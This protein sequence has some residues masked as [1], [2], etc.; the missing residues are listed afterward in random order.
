MTQPSGLQRFAPLSTPPLYSWLVQQERKQELPAGPQ[1]F[2]ADISLLFHQDPDV[3]LP[4]I[5][6][7]KC[8]L[9]RRVGRLAGDLPIKASYI[10]FGRESAEEGYEIFQEAMA[11]IGVLLCRHIHHPTNRFELAHLEQSDLIFLDRGERK[12]LWE[13]LGTDLGGSEVAE[14]VKWRYL[15]GAVVIAVGESMTLL[16]EKSWYWSNDVAIPFKGWCI[17]PHIVAPEDGTDMEELVEQFGG[18]GVVILGIHKGGGMIFNKDGLV[19][20]ARQ[21]IQEYRWDWQSK[22]VKQALLLG[23]PRNT[24]LICPLYTASREVAGDDELHDVYAYALTVEEEEEE[25]RLI[26]KFDPFDRWLDVQTQQEL[27]ALKKQGNEAFKAG[28][29]DVAFLHYNQAQVLLCSAAKPWPELPEKLRMAIEAKSEETASQGCSPRK[30]D[31]QACAIELSLLLNI[32]A[33]SLLAYSQD[34]SRK[35]EKPDPEEDLKPKSSNGKDPA[36]MMLVEVKDNLVVAFR[37]ANDALRLSLA[38]SAKAWFRR[39]TA[40]EKMRDYRNAVLDLEEALLR[41]PQDKAIVKKRNEMRDLASHVAENMYYARHKELDAQEQR[42]NLETRRALHLRGYLGFDKYEDKDLQFALQQPAARVVDSTLEELD[43]RLSL[44]LPMPSEAREDAPYLHTHALWTW[45]FLVQRSVGLRILCIEDV[46]LGSGPLEWL[47]KGLRSHQEIQALHFTGVHLGPA[48]AKMMRNVLAQ[49]KSLIDVKLDRCGILDSGL[50]ELA[51]GLADHCGPL[52]FLSLRQNTITFK[53]L[54]KLVSALCRDESKLAL[55]ELDLSE[56]PLGAAGAKELAKLFSSD[57]HKLRVLRLQD[58]LL[59]LAAFWRL[60]AKL[61]NDRPL[62]HLDLRLNPIGRGTRRC[63]RGTMAPNIRCDAGG[64]GGKQ[65][66]K[67]PEARSRSCPSSVLVPSSGARPGAP[68][69]VLA[70]SSDAL[71]S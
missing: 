46:D 16:G 23:P 62:T 19:E 63:W 61:D 53:K 35:L 50:A 24:G 71:C 55:G 30:E 38:R 7:V 20:P 10:G 48:G 60:V 33:C 44:R 51:E 8:E 15:Q 6:R 27:D 67:A 42:L 12:R 39:A 65:C 49:N 9:P 64:P 58:C 41:E 43:G 66:D 11:E 13:T 18:A 29:A 2:L 14:H 37:A 26:S 45:E 36:S 69:S 5:H 59:D 1:I 32:S 4:W 54:S 47:C 31:Y 52:E 56:N 40:F 25:Q 22:S 28:K 68:S 34:L 57:E 17:F 3:K 21:M 70:P